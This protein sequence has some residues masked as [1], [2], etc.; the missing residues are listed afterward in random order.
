MT[1]SYDYKVLNSSQQT[2]F[3]QEGEDIIL[4]K[5]F[6]LGTNR[7]KR[8]GIYVDVG[9]HHPMRFS[10]THLLSQRFGWT[11]VNIDPNPGFKAL[12]DKHRPADVN[13]QLAVSSTRGEAEFHLFDDPALNTFSREYVTEVLSWGSRT[14]LGTTRV[15]TDTLA[16]IF[17]DYVRGREVDLLTVDAEDHDYVV[18]AS[19]DW[20]RHRPHVVLVESLGRD[21]DTIFE[22]PSYQ[23]LREA[24]YRL[25]AK[26]C[27]TCIYRDQDWVRAFSAST[28]GETQA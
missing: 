11:G 18:L 3:A 26:T 4:C 13:L 27:S 12:F 1:V 7:V 16:G 15:R 17:N 14:Y 10:N 23:L 24:G 21:L 28:P 25:Y 6:C 5:L 2:S 22:D 9:A 8:N 19:G 20:Q